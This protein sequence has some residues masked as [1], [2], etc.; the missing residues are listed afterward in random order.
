MT[1]EETKLSRDIGRLEGKIDAVIAKT[2]SN[3]LAAAA[4][5]TKMDAIAHTLD[6][7]IGQD[8]QWMT[9]VDAR[10]RR[11][12]QT[13]AEVTQNH[14]TRI[15]ALERRG[16]WF[17]GWLASGSVLVTLVSAWIVQHFRSNH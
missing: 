11:Y 7:H 6:R 14:H 17:S 3:E 5:V 15:E 4:V 16:S 13:T 12:E 1:Q 9:G 8:E 10:L 2:N